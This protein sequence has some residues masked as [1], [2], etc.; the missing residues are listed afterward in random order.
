ETLPTAPGCATNITPADN[1]TGVPVSADITWDAVA[2]ATGYRISIGTTS[3]ATEI[4]DNINVNGTTFN[5]PSDLPENETIYVSVVPYNTVGSATG[6]P[7][8][9]FTTET[10][11]TI[12]G[13]TSIT[14]S[15]E[16]RVGNADQ[17][18]RSPYAVAKTSCYQ[19]SVPTTARA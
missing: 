13:C 6:C 1:A 17:S 9:S 18:G 19:L 12:P 2:G 8:I 15:E 14:R 3:G 7:E 16:R 5:P 10:L 11:P 4:A